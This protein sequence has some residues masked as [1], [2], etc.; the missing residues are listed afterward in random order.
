MKAR[1][2]GL[3]RVRRA[4]C[5]SVL[6]AEAVTDHRDVLAGFLVAAGD[7]AAGRLRSGLEGYHIRALRTLLLD[8]EPDHVLAADR[9]GFRHAVVTD[10]MDLRDC[11]FA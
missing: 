9:V 2:S 6:D 10:L 7:A 8:R 1:F 4:M 5:F 3:C 11:C